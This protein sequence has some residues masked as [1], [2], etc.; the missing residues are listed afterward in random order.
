MRREYAKAHSC[1]EKVYLTLDSQ[2]ANDWR[3]LA[4]VEGIQDPRS[5]RQWRF[6]DKALELDPSSYDTFFLRGIVF[7]GEGEYQKALDDFNR[8]IAIQDNFEIRGLRG[9]A[10]CGTGQISRAITD[11]EQYLSMSPTMPQPFLFKCLAVCYLQEEQYSQALAILKKAEIL[12]PEDTDFSL[13]CFAIYLH[14]QNTQE[15]QK[16]LEIC[17][18]IAPDAPE[19]Q[20]FEALWQVYNGNSTQGMKKLVSLEILADQGQITH[21]FVELLWMELAIRNYEQT[22]LFFKSSE[23]C[24]ES[25]EYFLKKLTTLKEKLKQFPNCTT[26]FQTLDIAEIPS[27]FLRQDE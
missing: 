24:V 12:F 23:F 1:L 10:Y 22:E 15:C 2:R 7:L 18:K 17:L 16:S 3:R 9:L 27:L 4:V 20:L 14:C 25:Q 5:S 26:V 8:G 21:S 13:M 6:F 19:V 11:L